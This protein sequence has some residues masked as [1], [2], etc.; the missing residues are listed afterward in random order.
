MTCS[1]N[2]RLNAARTGCGNAPGPVVTKQCSAG[3][4]TGKHDSPPLSQSIHLLDL[5]MPSVSC[6][7]LQHPLSGGAPYRQSG[8]SYAW[9]PTG[10]HLRMYGMEGAAPRNKKSPRS[11]GATAPARPAS[12]SRVAV[13]A[14]AENGRTLANGI[15][16]RI[17]LAHAS[18][19][20][21]AKDVR[22]AG[23]A[24]LI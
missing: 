14:R 7:K 6:N 11:S 19:K 12:V 5:W 1:Q 15:A 4:P 16:A 10:R 20:V 3:A 24:A 18:E 9:R 21:P 2:L 22:S 17:L 23:V 8:R 13:P